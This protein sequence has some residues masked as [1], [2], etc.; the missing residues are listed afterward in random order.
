M[1]TL[2]LLI[3]AAGLACAQSMIYLG[4]GPSL[5]S[6]LPYGAFNVTLGL[7]TSD[8]STCAMLNYQARGSSWAPSAIEYTSSAGVRQVVGSAAGP[9]GRVDLFLLGDAG[10]TIVASSAG[11]SGAG[12]GGLTLHLN[13][14]PSWSASIAAQAEYSPVNPGW[15]PQTFFQIGYLFK[16]R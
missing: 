1:K 6:V 8:A 11:F 9:A 7:C 12:G 10:A 15:R 14:F 3:A 13:R 2:L 16:G 5:H 4:A